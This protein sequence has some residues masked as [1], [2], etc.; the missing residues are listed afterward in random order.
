MATQLPV[1]SGKAD[2][3]AVLLF[4]NQIE[5]CL[6]QPA[7][8][9]GFKSMADLKYPQQLT[10]KRLAPIN[11]GFD[12]FKLQL[13]FAGHADAASAQVA[14][15]DLFGLRALLTGINGRDDAFGWCE[16]MIE[17]KH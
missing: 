7:D 9:H 13:A 3:F 4:G 8:C 6:A 15:R 14:A 1:D 17:I 11:G 10:R 2:L 16:S 12:I 5:P